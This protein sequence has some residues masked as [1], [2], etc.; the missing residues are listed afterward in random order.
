MSTAMRD[1]IVMLL[2]ALAA[3]FAVGLAFARAWD[4]KPQKVLLMDQAR[5]SSGCPVSQQDPPDGKHT[6]CRM[7][8]GPWFPAR[9]DGVCYADDDATA[10]TKQW[11]PSMV[12]TG[13]LVAATEHTLTLDWDQL[14]DPRDG[15]LVTL[16]NGA[17]AW[18]VRMVA[19]VNGPKLSIYPDWANVPQPGD[20]YIIFYTSERGEQ[21]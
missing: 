10:R 3:G 11:D 2:A 19:V 5:P 6:W 17:A 7:A 1:R 12:H 21:K 13:K 14:G 8:C 20:V 16:T 18:Q 15:Y 9:E 4:S